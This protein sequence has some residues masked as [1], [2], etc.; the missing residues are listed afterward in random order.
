MYN[1]LTD[2][3]KN[4]GKTVKQVQLVNQRPN[5]VNNEI[6]H[7]QERNADVFD[8]EFNHHVEIQDSYSRP[9]VLGIQNTNLMDEENLGECWSESSVFAVNT[10]SSLIILPLH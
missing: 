1:K 4:L 5:P 10:A 8:I 2:P 3:E 9:N 7:D 6:S